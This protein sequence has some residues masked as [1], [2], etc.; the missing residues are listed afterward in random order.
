VDG[1]TMSLCLAC[2]HELRESDEWT[3]DDGAFTS[4]DG[5]PLT[6]AEH[7]GH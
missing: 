1:H 3:E 4:R 7:M 6:T 2:V 5:V